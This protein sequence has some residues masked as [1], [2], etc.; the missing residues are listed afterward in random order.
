MWIGAVLAGAIVLVW[1]LQHMNPGQVTIARMDHDLERIHE[2]MNLA[3]VSESSS[4]NI[5]IRSK[6]K[7]MVNDTTLCITAII[8][9]GNETRCLPTPCTIQPALLDIDQGRLGVRKDAGL[10][11][12][13][14]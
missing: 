14:P 13:I 7:L 11:S 8:M 10:V 6:G 2:Q 3:C 9:E 1:Y 4:S 12:V 5:P